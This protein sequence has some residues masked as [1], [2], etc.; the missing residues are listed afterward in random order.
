MT[1]VSYFITVRDVSLSFFIP[2]PAD[3]E[4]T[5]EAQRELSHEPLPTKTVGSMKRG[6]VRMASSLRVKHAEDFGRRPIG[7][8]EQTGSPP[9]DT[10][11][12][13]DHGMERNV[14]TRD[15]NNTDS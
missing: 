15:M 5:L 4:E 3:E 9:D 11:N 6:M 8:K 7:E 10:E 12:S 1:N 14:D 13:S 2:S